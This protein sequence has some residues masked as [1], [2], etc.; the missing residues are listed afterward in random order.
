MRIKTLNIFKVFVVLIIFVYVRLFPINSFTNKINALI[1]LFISIVLLLK[2][3]KNLPLILVFFF[4]FYINYS[5]VMGEYIIGGDLSIPLTQVKTE[6]IYGLTIRILLMFMSILTIFYN[7]KSFELTKHKLEPK[8][9]FLLYYL[10]L[11]VLIGILIFGVDRMET[12]SYNVKISP[13]YEYSKLLFLFLYYFSGKLNIRKI[14]FKIIMGAFILQDVYYGGRI[15]SMQLLIL[16]SITVW[17]EK[18]NFKKIIGYGFIGI[19]F[20]NIVG[21]YRQSYKLIGISVVNL[22]KNL[23][24]NYFVFDTA[25]YAYYASATH[26]AASKVASMGIRIN[27]FYEF[28]K[29]IF[30]LSK[31]LSRDVTRLV[32]NNY[33]LNIGGGLIPTHFYF[34]LG[35]F[36]VF[37][38]SFIVVL[39]INSLR[40]NDNEYHKILFYAV[41]VNVPRWYLYSPNQLFKGSLYIVTVLWG[42]YLIGQKFTT[43]KRY[44]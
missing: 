43:K 4:I 3:R 29:S 12:T 1:T 33:I 6:E 37:L 24:L 26:V 16:F 7:G 28:F 19:V 44:L 42:V 14:L 41:V 17:A 22:I 23:F 8:N 31:S 18:L 10:T 13:V 25:I 32:A 30:G 38:I 36:G 5:I 35:W 27:S 21:V 15:T 40:F 9:N 2:G 39:L 11:F 20:N 34:W